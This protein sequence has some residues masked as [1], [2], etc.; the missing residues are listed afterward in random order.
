MVLVRSQIPDHPYAHWLPRVSAYVRDGK[1]LAISCVSRSLPQLCHVAA[2]S[3]TR[4]QD[5]G[6][7]NPIPPFA[8]K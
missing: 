7:S 4:L 5:R 1:F 3:S 6:G 8:T 2:I